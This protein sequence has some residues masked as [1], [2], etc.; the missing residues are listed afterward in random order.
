[1]A[2]AVATAHDPRSTVDYWLEQ[3]INGSAGHHAA[4]DAFM[5]DAA[6][7]AV[8]IFVAIVAA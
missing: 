5:R 2:A 4:L 8:P 3:I 7:W 6:G 1:M